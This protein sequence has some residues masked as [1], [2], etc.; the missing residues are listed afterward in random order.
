MV[1]P[2][3]IAEYRQQLLELLP[4]GKAWPREPGTVLARLMTAEA[5]TLSEIDRVAVG[6]L[7]EL[8]PGTTLA[9]LEDWE[10]SVGLP[11]ECTDLETTIPARR[12]ALL[13]KI[14]NRSN[15]SRATYERI[16]AEFGIEITIAEHDEVRAGE[17]SKH[18]TAGGK[19]RHVFWIEAPSPSPP[20]RF[21]MLSDVNTPLL[22]VERNTELECRLRAAS[23][24]H[25][26]LIVEYTE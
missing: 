19:W 26:E 25:T 7:A 1:Q 4:R 17:D 10:R 16:A 8:N 5:A 23:P 22:T 6:L 9:L 15:M 13:D 24:A 11:D 12:A 21:N 18:D 3:G 14:V 2:V 20:M